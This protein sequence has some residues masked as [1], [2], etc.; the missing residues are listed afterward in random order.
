MLAM[1]L[2]NFPE[3]I[4]TF[5]AGV[6]DLSMGISLSIAIAFHNIPEGI[7]VAMPIYYSTGSKRKLSWPPSGLELQSPSGRWL[8]LLLRP[9][10]N[11]LVLGA[12]FALVAG[13]MLYISLEEL[14][15]LQDNTARTGLL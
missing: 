2:H 8:P 6:H 10:I 9:F 15:P 13:I 14:L 11:D 3:G 12:S 1:A 7:S 5:M 4:A